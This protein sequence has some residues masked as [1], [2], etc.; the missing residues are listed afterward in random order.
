[1]RLETL[2][3]PVVAAINGAALGGGLEIALACHHRIV[4]DVPGAVVGFPEVTHRPDARRWWGGSLGADVRDP[5]GVHGGAEP[6]HAVHAGQGP[7]I[8]LWSTRSLP[9][10]E[11]LVARREG[12]DQGQPRG[13]HP[14]VGCQ[15]LQDARRHPVSPGLAAHPA[16]VPGAACASSSRVRRC[17]APRAILDAAVEGAQVDFDTASRIES[18]YFTS[19]VTGQVSKNMIQAFFLDL[20]YINSGRLAPRRHR[21]AAGHQDRRAR[22]RHDGRRHRLRVGQGRL[23]RGAQGRLD[24]GGGEGQEV[25][26][27]AGGQGARAR[28]DHPGEARRVLG[29]ITPT[30][31]AADFRAVDFVIEAVFEYARAQA[32]GVRR[33]SRTS[34]S[35]T[36][37]SGRTPRR[38][39]S[40]VWRPV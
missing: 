18:R 35:P 31:E 11:E 13:P 21:Q 37:C 10:V 30:A 38:C 33:R 28:A 24:R 1:M 3:V 15:G 39:R 2:G 23:R 7:G 20:Q 26:G 5:E 16:V 14:A 6:G 17:P 29:R 40:P 8:G 4:A 19:L 27:E 9:T 25:L 32:P 34:S 12:V 36:R 22:R